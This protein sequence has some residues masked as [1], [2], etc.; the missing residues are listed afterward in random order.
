[1]PVESRE[2]YLQSIVRAAAPGASYFVLVFDRAAIPEGPIN[3]V[4][5]D[6]LRAAVS[7]YW[8]IDEIK[9]AR[10]YARFPAGFAGMPALLDIREEPNGL[11]SIGGWLLSAHLG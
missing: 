7:K 5:E 9:P 6:E 1:M 3:A 4:T 8:I 2:G 11:Q 10:L